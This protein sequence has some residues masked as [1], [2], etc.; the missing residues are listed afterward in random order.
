MRRPALVICDRKTNSMRSCVRKC[1]RLLIAFSV[2]LF[3]TAVR[4][5]TEPPICA[6][7]DLSACGSTSPSV[8][9]TPSGD[10]GVGSSSR[11]L[12]NMIPGAPNAPMSVYRDDADG[13]DRTAGIRQHPAGLFKTQPLIE[14]QMLVTGSIGRIVPDP[15]VPPQ[16]AVPHGMRRPVDGV[17]LQSRFICCI[18]YLISTRHLC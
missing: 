14:F 2:A 12:P 3:L 13:I 7:G 5:Q 16:D 8:E 9:P 15:A 18:S 10:G 11:S 1:S 6:H 17:C 4:A